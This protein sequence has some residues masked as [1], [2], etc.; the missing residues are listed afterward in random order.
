MIRYK[1]S[2]FFL[3]F[4]GY[5]VREPIIIRISSGVTPLHITLRLSL[6]YDMLLTSKKALT[7]IST[8]KYLMSVRIEV[9]RVHYLVL[10]GLNHLLVIRRK[11]GRV[12]NIHLPSIL[13]TSSLLKVHIARGVE[14]WVLSLGEI[15]L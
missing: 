1:S 10:S 11:L 7:V 3:V 9:S 2:V 15:L 4:A 12:I 8:Q 14:A 6:P 13:V 5:S